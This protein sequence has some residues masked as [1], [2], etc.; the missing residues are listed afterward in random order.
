[1]AQRA[2]ALAAELGALV[3]VESVRHLQ[4][5]HDVCEVAAAF[6]VR[7]SPPQNY[8]QMN[9]APQALLRSS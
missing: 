6:Q 1:M 8:L 5:I 9:S 3:R 7:P 4:T 2:A